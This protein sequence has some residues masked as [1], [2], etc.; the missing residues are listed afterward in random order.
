MLCA[1]NSRIASR[2]VGGGEQT[3]QLDINKC[4]EL[5]NFSVNIKTTLGTLS[6]SLRRPLLK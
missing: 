6:K 1:Q 4:V 3:L 2:G 5:S